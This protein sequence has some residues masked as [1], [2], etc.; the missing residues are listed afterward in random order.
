MTNTIS[1][2]EGYAGCDPAASASITALAKPKV[3]RILSDSYADR[4]RVQVEAALREAKEEVI[5]Q[6]TQRGVFRFSVGAAYL[7]TC[8][9]GLCVCTV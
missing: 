8:C 3:A 6:L 5:Q 4:S 9:Y 2:S 7:P 1:K